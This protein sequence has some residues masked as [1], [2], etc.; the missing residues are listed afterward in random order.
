MKININEIWQRLVIFVEGSLVAR[1]IISLSYLVGMVVVLIF[2][3]KLIFWG[4]ALKENRDKKNKSE[5]IFV[6]LAEASGF[7]KDI[8]GIKQFELYQWTSKK[9][10]K[11]ENNQKKLKYISIS[12]VMPEYFPHLKKH[13]LG[14]EIYCVHGR[15]RKKY[16][17]L[18]YGDIEDKYFVSYKFGV[19][20]ESNETFEKRREVMNIKKSEPDMD[21]VANIM[22]K[23][24]IDSHSALYDGNCFEA[25]RGWIKE[26]VD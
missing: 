7:D 18:V 13:S 3:V 19:Q 26:E 5:E 25:M 22:F 23:N 1:I 14:R 11:N 20:L 2:V 10:E 24:Y 6:K 8:I 17:E 15:V 4:M 16:S 12:D 9:E 21:R